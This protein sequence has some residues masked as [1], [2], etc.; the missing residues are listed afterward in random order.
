MAALRISKV[1]GV[2]VVERYNNLADIYDYLVQGVD[3]SGW[4]DY[5][6]QIMES[7]NFKP[8]S[9]L[10]MACG[11]G[12][13]LEPLAHRGLKA[14]GVDIS[15][16]MIGRAKENSQKKGLDIEY[17][18]ADMG[19]F[20]GR[21]GVDLV[22][23]FHDGLNYILSIEGIKKIFARV[24]Q[25]LNPGGM[26]IFDLNAILWIDKLEDSST[27]AVEEE[28]FTLIY[29]SC[30]DKSSLMWTVK[31]TGFLRFGEEEAVYKKFKEIHTERGYSPG[32]IN[33]ALVQCGLTPL[34]VYDAFSFNSP[35]RNSRRHFY[36]ATKKL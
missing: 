33:N 14:T 12:K 8:L 5:V 10:D 32:E 15:P 27:V 25:N 28:D 3:F 18:V 16:E 17:H 34:A 2:D 35:E 20:I 21:F 31:L 30:Y 4:I 19:D 24:Y 23:C 13:T 29:E 6:V 7:F 26:F 1:K 9:V 11:T 22:T 36:V